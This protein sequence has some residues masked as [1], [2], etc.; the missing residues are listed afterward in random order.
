MKSREE[1]TPY[2]EKEMWQRKEGKKTQMRLP[3]S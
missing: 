2:K 1:A 3:V